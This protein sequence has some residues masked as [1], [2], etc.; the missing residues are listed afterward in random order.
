MPV[1]QELLD[2]LACPLCREEVR[3]TPDGSGLKCIKCHR[4]YPI[5]DGIPIML[6]DEATLETED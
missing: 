5:K 3:L 6:I 1:P 2:I 4:I